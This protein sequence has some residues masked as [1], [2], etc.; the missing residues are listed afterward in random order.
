MP[1]TVANMVFGAPSSIKLGAYGAA[2][3][4]CTDLG[5]TEGGLKITSKVGTYEFKADQAVGTVAVAITERGY[6]IEFEVAEPTLALFQQALGYPSEQ[7]AA[8]TLS[9]GNSTVVTYFTMY[10][11]GVGPNGGT[12]KVTI[13]K[14]VPI[15]DP[16]MQ[17]TKKDK[18]VYAMKMLVIQDTSKTDVEQFG[19]IDDSGVDTTPPTVALTT[20]IEDGTVTKNT[21]GTVTLTFTEAGQGIDEG[22]LVDGKTIMVVN[23]TTQAQNVKVAGAWVY[24]AAAKTLIFTPTGTWTASDKLCVIITT[25]VRDMAGNAL[26]ATFIGN[27]TVTA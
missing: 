16:V 23:V 11:N 1:G 8:N 12:R 15:G 4:G 27:F 13:Y 24:T 3:G 25:G 14:C 6:T 19:K 10:I 9:L 21:N 2:E 18:T 20:P 7:L 26:A 5:F 17:M 22:S